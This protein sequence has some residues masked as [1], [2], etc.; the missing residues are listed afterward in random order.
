[1]EILYNIERVDLTELDPSTGKPATG[2]TAIKTTIKTAKEA[3][4]AAV[5]SEGAEEILRNATSIL[6]VV[7]EDDLLYGYDFTFTDNTFDIKAA[8]LVAGYVKA[9]GTGAGEMIY[10]LQ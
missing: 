7:R 6:A 3:K 1:M 4:L 2:E 8:Q 9:T 5:I 10:R